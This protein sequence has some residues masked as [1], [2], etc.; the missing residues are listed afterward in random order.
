MWDFNS[1]L[2]NPCITGKVPNQF[3]NED[4]DYNCEKAII[5]WTLDFEMREYGIKDTYIH[6]KKVTLVFDDFNYGTKSYIIDDD[7]Y[8]KDDGFSLIS[9]WYDREDFKWLTIFPV[10][11]CVDLDEKEVEVEF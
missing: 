1:E 7:E 5:E 11:I 4:G 9:K 6:I 2:K 3:L 10:E 8:Y